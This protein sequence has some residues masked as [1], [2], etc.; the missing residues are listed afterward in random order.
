[1]NLNVQPDTS[2]QDEN[3]STARRTQA[4]RTAISDAAMI[5][6]AIDIIVARGT[7]G[8]TLKDVGEHAGYSRGLASYRF[9]SKSGLFAAIIRSVGESWLRELQAATSNRQGLDA[10]LAA[11]DAHA[12]LIA[13]GA[14]AIQAF[15]ILWFNSIGPD[16]ALRQVIANVHERR[17]RD[18]EAWI[19]SGLEH[20]NI[21]PTVDIRAVAGQFC[22]TIVGI[23]YQWLAR[24]DSLDDV[25]QL[26][27]GLKAEMTS[28]LGLDA[29]S[30][31]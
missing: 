19:Q 2:V 16:H 9:G 11:T 28:L 10:V 29:S 24:P 15:Y 20:G 22:A 25:M 27:D 18:V 17:Q 23:V 26:H 7:S 4:E 13:A 1:M 31:D 14:P 21:S 30:N 6:A 12:R 3:A 5:N 8:L